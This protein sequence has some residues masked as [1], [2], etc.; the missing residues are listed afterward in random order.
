MNSSEN[1]LGRN[2]LFKL[3]KAI[4]EDE[5]KDF[6]RFV[7]SPYLNSGRNYLQLV[8]ILKRFHPDFNHPDFTRENI[9]EKLYPG[10]EYKESVLNTMLSRLYA[11]GENYLVYAAL[12]KD[13]E[14][15]KEKLLI[16]ELT[17]RGTMLKLN[18]TI[19]NDLSYLSNKPFEPNDFKILKEINR[20]VLLLNEVN[21]KNDLIY[22]NLISILKNMVLHFLYE[23]SLNLST[24]Y[25]YKSYWKEDFQLNPLSSL[26]PDSEIERIAS[27][28]E[29]ADPEKGLPVRLALLSYLATK[30]PD[31]DEYY[32][33]LKE[34]VFN[35]YDKLGEQ[36][37]HVFINNLSSIA[38]QKFL[39]GRSEFK[40]E[41]FELR[42]L[43]FEKDEFIH[44]R[45]YI[46]PGELRTS[47][48]DAMN[49][50]EPVWAA[51][52]RD[53]YLPMIN[54]ELRNEMRCYCNA[55][56]AYTNGDLDSALDNA[57]RV[58]INQI[59]F[60]L[61][62]KNIIARIYY[63][64]DSIEPLNSHLS[65]YRQLLATSDSRN[66]IFLTRHRNYIKYLRKLVSLKHKRN[67]EPD[68]SI[69]R[70]TVKK[71]NLTSKT[72]LLEKI[73]EL[74]NPRS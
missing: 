31:N 19:S 23:Y 57:C 24:I 9:Y 10:K 4:R 16:R 74:G 28:L 39:E 69:L 43:Q 15:L 14:M 71:D 54:P 46:R 62:M 66:K 38:I 45:G 72:W 3:L 55:W 21:G 17:S 1:T 6:E 41:T 51:K 2:I 44:K 32:H 33:K 52:F 26:M 63:E 25:S 56:L 65:A 30:H 64:T 48:L 11:V 58:N 29:N 61:D 50:G 70:D 37:R 73:R 36:T 68:L 49:A 20:E 59:I 27:E 67:R 40:R 13:N 47:F 60:K 53:R 5:W 34:L 7:S 42:R 12:D 18:K 8:K 22:E 35:A